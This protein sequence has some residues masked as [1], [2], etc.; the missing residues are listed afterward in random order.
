MGVS[1]K[2]WK[3]LRGKGLPEK[4]TAAILGNFQA[5]SEFDINK[6]EAGGGGG[7]GLAQWTGGRRAQLERY[8][9]SLD[10]QLNFLWAELSGE[11]ASSVGAKLQW[12]NKSKYLSHKNFMAGNG[13]ISE[14]TAAFC[15][16]W[17]RP[18]E[19]ES[20]SHLQS[21]RIPKA[22]EY[23]TKF[24][25]LQGEYTPNAVAGE[26]G[27]AGI[28]PLMDVEATN[29]QV[30]EGSKKQGD[31]LFGRRYRITV[32]NESGKTVDV[33]QLH[34]T[35]S[36]LKTIQMEPNLSEIS[37]YNLNAQTENDIKTNGTRVTI[38]AGYEG[39]N[40]GLIFDGDI[41]QC[42]QEK[43][44]AHTY[45]LTIIALDSDR[46][47][48][49]E[50]SNFSVLRGQS[51]REI[52]ETIVNNAKNPMELGSISDKL[53]KTKL[54]RGKVMLGKSS[55]YLNQIAKSNGLQFYMDDGRVNLIDL[56]ELPK[57]EIIKLSPD[58]G[59]IGVPEQTDFGVNGQCLL[60]PHIRLNSLIHIENHLV[61]DKRIEFGT[62]NT[63]PVDVGDSNVT[64]SGSG[65][66]GQPSRDG[67]LI[68]YD[69]TFTITSHF[70]PRGGG[71]HNGI[72]IGMP[73]GTPLY[74]SKA[75]K[76]LKAGVDSAG[77]NSGGGKIVML[78]H[79]DGSSTNY[80][81]LSD[82]KVKTGETVRQGQI[83]GLSGNTGRS[84]GPHLHFEIKEN[85]KFKN[86]L[87][88]IEG[89]GKNPPPSIPSVNEGANNPSNDSNA[90]SSSIEHVHS[91]I[92]GLDKDGI[93]R[94]VKLEYQGNTR[95]NEWF[96]HFQ[97][98]TQIGGQIPII[99]T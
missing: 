19:A 81:H 35:F 18:K 53:N 1:E 24:T 32:S 9:T 65:S 76:V 6:I 63:V 14:L 31:Y 13:S 28:P 15:H 73:T 69:G 41:I 82:W 50:I 70:G 78:S 8:G 60:N 96:V 92:R 66:G 77:I 55:D 52:V 37:I 42:I 7:F 43:E 95:G 40:F 30:V 48:N 49:F 44:Q 99:S 98:I 38:E 80:F 79:Q 64:S 11:G 75:G 94:V 90:S 12:M 68:P 56:K 58:S 3:F 57:D 71:H 33:S 20:V 85:G 74:A 67:Y 84:S 54:T 97:T 27:N 47:I 29:Y 46:A 83:I 88:V 10:H 36:V 39:S 25:G 4:S 23:Y 2:V 72:D 86:P 17:E 45:K 22:N 34:C 21:R 26:N 62:S 93:Y 51:H 16:C 61:R 87:S 91:L 59:L 5:E 89:G